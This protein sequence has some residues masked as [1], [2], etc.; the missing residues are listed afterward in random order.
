VL[1]L[2]LFLSFFLTLSLSSSFLAILTLW[3]ITL[4]LHRK[5]NTNITHICILRKLCSRGDTFA[6]CCLS[7]T[8]SIYSL[9]VNSRRWYGDHHIQWPQVKRDGRTRIKELTGWLGLQ[10]CSTV[11]KRAMPFPIRHCPRALFLL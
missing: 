5:K 8:R 1:F 10:T 3:S 4:H 9:G 6:H 7:W 2:S 11:H